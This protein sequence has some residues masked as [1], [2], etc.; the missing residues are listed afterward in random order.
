MTKDLIP[1]CASLRI[2]I[3]R[4][5]FHLESELHPSF[6]DNDD[7]IIRITDHR[8]NHVVY[9]DLNLIDYRFEENALLITG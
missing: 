6:I 7:N 4:D 1:S 9:A 5:E 3:K 2:S 8:Q